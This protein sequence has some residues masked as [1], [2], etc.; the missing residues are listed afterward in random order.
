[1]DH[2][3]T[4]VHLFRQARGAHIPYL[5]ADALIVV[6]VEAWALSSRPKVDID[7]VKMV[8]RPVLTG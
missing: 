3:H 8:V 6:D 1:M 7:T 2:L 5:Y 4:V